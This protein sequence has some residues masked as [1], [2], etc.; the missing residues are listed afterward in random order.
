MPNA[1]IIQKASLAS[2]EAQ[3]LITELNQSLASANPDPAAHSWTLSTAD[4]SPN[5]GAFVI[6]YD[7]ETNE[8][9]GCGAIR[10]IAWDN[11]SSDVSSAVAELKRMFV[12]STHRG[13]G[14]GKQIVTELE[15]IARHE[16]GVSMLVLETGPYLTGAIAM[17]R[18]CGFDVIPLFGEYEEKGEKFSLCILY[19]VNSHNNPISP[20][21]T[22]PGTFECSWLDKRLA[23]SEF[24]HPRHKH[25]PIDHT[26]NLAHTPAA[27]IT[28]ATLDQEILN[29]INNPL[30][31]LHQTWKTTC[32]HPS[33]V[34]EMLS[35]HINKTD[36]T[37]ND[38]L[39]TVFYDDA[40]VDAWVHQRFRGTKA[41]VV[42]NWIALN[43]EWTN[44]RVMQERLAYA[45]VK[46]SD[47]FRIMVVWYYGGLYMDIDVRKEQSWRPL[48]HGNTAVMAFEGNRDYALCGMYAAGVAGHP[49][50]SFLLDFIVEAALDMGRSLA[51]S[52]SPMDLAGPKAVARAYQAYSEN[53]GVGG[54]F[55]LVALSNELVQGERD[56]QDSCPGCWANHIN[57]C[58]WCHKDGG[59]NPGISEGCQEVSKFMPKGSLI[60]V[61]A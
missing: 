7:S 20:P 60:S 23:D 17:Y 28:A 54:E 12:K 34:Q 45:G 19:L 26:Q 35:W 10:K 21:N 29:P 8:A 48:V 56:N 2:L 39:R 31:H 14:I 16:C 9:I 46:R 22:L 18:R 47:L 49:F 52:C 3:S 1:I 4:V 27:P 58:T 55:P 11:S 43:D 53:C 44:P 24:S 61:N 30:L 6:A 33:K 57:N 36:P 32:V 25:D 13:K 15:R 59:E 38:A 41:L 5:L 51:R 40:A 50:F 37:D 42:W